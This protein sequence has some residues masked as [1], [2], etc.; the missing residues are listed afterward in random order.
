MQTCSLNKFM[1]VSIQTSQQQIVFFGSREIKAFETIGGAIIVDFLRNKALLAS[2]WNK[3]D[4]DYLLLV[5]SIITRYGGFELLISNLLY[6][7]YPW[8]SMI[9]SVP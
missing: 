1:P 7:F 3:R 2:L 6:L 9:D 5:G 8:F 4:V